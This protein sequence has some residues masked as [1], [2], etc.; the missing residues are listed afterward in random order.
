MSLQG[1]YEVYDEEHECASILPSSSLILPCLD[2]PRISLC[3]MLMGPAGSSNGF[4]F[5][6]VESLFLILPLKTLIEGNVTY[7]TFA[8]LLQW[9][10]PRVKEVNVEMPFDKLQYLKEKVSVVF[11]YG[12]SEA[13][14]SRPH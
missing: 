12:N 7:P 13:V 5:E 8:I 9:N 6:H 14:E 4:W 3:E 10:L 1:T 11:P 2:V